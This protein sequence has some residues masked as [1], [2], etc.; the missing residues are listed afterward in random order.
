MLVFTHN[1]YDFYHNLQHSPCV[2]LG[3]DIGKKNVGLSISSYEWL[4]ASPLC[5]FTRKSG[6]DDSLFIEHLLDKH[7]VRG[8]VCGMPLSMDGSFSAH[9]Q[10]IVDWCKWLFQNLK[11]HGKG[12]SILMWD[13]RLS[14]RA[15]NQ[16]VSLDTLGR[17]KKRQ[18]K[19]DTHDKLAATYLL[20][21]ALEI[22]QR[23]HIAAQ[24]KQI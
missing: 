12:V 18:L 11:E 9:S 14:S 7:Q 3:L 8:L 20:Q 24:N 19:G 6:Y 4:I 23:H 2:L 5:S 15:I 13:E 22:L 10:S 17:K 1:H 21:S 16:V